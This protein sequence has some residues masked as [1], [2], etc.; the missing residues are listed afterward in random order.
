MI[1]TETKKLIDQLEKM[2]A[3]CPP[4]PWEFGGNV[5]FYVDVRKPRPSLS[6][7]DDARPSY[8]HYDDGL[9]VSAAIHSVPKLIEEIKRLELALDQ[10][11]Q[12]KEN[13]HE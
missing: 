13:A 9:Y 8:W 10:A 4:F 5:P 7:H 12:T 6:K 1:T 3:K 11:L 2:L